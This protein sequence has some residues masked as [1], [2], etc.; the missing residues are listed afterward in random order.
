VRVPLGYRAQEE[1]GFVEFWL[2]RWLLEE[3]EP[4]YL[5]TQR[6]S[7]EVDTV[8]LHDMHLIKLIAEG[9]EAELPLLVLSKHPIPLNS[10]SIY[11]DHFRKFLLSNLKMKSASI[12]SSVSF[13]KAS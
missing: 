5:F 2:E 1:L 12:E 9:Y 4:R 3:G 6:E 10:L 7:R 11:S 8:D 13:S